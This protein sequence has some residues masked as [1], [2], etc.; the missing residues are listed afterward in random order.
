L[1]VEDTLKTLV[2]STP[3]SDS[4]ALQQRVNIACEDMRMNRE[5]CAKYAPPFDER[6]NAVLKCF[7]TT[8]SAWRRDFTDIAHVS[9]GAGFWKYA[10]RALRLI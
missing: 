2:Y 9:A 6:L 10:D 1:A 8:Q 3:I 4:E 5:Y 7:G